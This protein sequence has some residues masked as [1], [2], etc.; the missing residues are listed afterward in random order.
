MCDFLNEIEDDSDPS[1]MAHQLI[2]KAYLDGSTDNLSVVLVP[3]GSR[4]LL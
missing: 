3:L 2:E 4:D 1:L